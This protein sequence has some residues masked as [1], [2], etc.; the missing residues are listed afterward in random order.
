[1]YPELM[2]VGLCAVQGPAPPS[3]PKSQPAYLRAGP[4]IHPELRGP[5]RLAGPPS[6][7]HHR[8]WSYALLERLL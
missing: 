6:R 2:L 7:R 5:I 4:G 3:E 1:M 8:L